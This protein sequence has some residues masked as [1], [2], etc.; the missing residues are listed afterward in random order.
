MRVK[1]ALTI[2]FE[3][4]YQPFAA[5]SLPG[6]ERFGSRVPQDTDRLLSLLRSLG[7]R[8]TFF[9]L[10][11]VAEQFPESIRAIHGDGHEIASHGHR[12]LPLFHQPRD[13]FETELEGS[14]GLLRELT[15]ERVLGFRAPFFSLRED[16]L[17]AVDV[18]KR[19]GVEYSSSIH[20][21]I[22]VF[23]GHQ[24]DKH[25]PFKHPNGIREFPITTLRLLGLPLPFGGGVYYRLLPYPAIRLGLDWLNRR[26]R[27]GV[28]YFHPREFDPDLPR[29]KAGPTVN[30]IVYAGI[31]SLESK[32]TR[33]AREFTFVPLQGARVTQP[34]DTQT[35]FDRIASEFAA[36]YDPSKGWLSA[37]CDAVF[38]RGME[39]RFRYVTEHMEWQDRTVLDV[40]CGPG[41]YM[42]QFVHKGA[43]KVVGLDFAPA[44]IELARAN[45]RDWGVDGRCSLICGDFLDAPLDEGFDSVVAI[46]Y[47]DYILG[48]RALD[49][50]FERMW[51]L[52]T[53][54]VVASFP[55][56]WSFKTLPR[57]IWLS[58]RHCP[59]Q[60]YSVEDV[61]ALMRRLAVSRFTIERMSGTIL[62]IAEKPERVPA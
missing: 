23:H 21:T 17:W 62:L 33:L 60:F 4:W 61:N 16:T 2:D 37:A 56:R 36:H 46:G 47:F 10:G 51:K 18:L 12:H 22:A 30:V 32:L 59:V 29:I 31:R 40:G 49:T 20:P 24:K 38:R 3:D 7:V 15:G 52:S 41:H 54:R 5:R 50:H 9:V 48:T 28:V 8:A 1:N 34:T 6:W 19:L 44:M 42:A 57:W 13:R 58:L 53:R 55:Y 25:L 39:Q 43:T 27:S 35:Y 14:L 11:E 45:L 26:G